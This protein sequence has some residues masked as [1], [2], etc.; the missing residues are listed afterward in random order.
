MEL[1]ISH[2]EKFLTISEQ[3][4]SVFVDKFFE[5]IPDTLK[6]KLKAA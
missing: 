2:A 4:I 1:F 5:A 6:I 3:D